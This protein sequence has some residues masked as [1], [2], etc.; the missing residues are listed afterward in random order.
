M[1]QSGSHCLFLVAAGSEV[2][3]RVC[4]EVCEENRQS[5]A[6]LLA[7]PLG[8]SEGS[9]ACA[10]PAR[11]MRERGDQSGEGPSKQKGFES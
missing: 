4:Q 7:G 5:L 8:V 2:V 6:H 10:L 3:V 1:T 11:A 9:A